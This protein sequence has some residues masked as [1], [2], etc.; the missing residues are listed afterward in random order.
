MHTHM[1]MYNMCLFVD[2]EKIEMMQKCCEVLSGEKRDRIDH[3]FQY[4]AETLRTFSLA[5][6]N[7]VLA[8]VNEIMLN[9]SEI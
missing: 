2:A 1:Q 9:N 7:R 3:F 5:N 6:Q 4:C 8:Q